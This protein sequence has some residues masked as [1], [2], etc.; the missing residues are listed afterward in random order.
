[1]YTYYTLN[2]ADKTDEA[3]EILRLNTVLYPEDI[4][5]WYVLAEAEEN[6][7]NL[8]DAMECYNRLLS[9]EPDIPDVRRSYNSL[10]LLDT[11]IDRGINDVAKVFEYLKK[12]HPDEINEGTLNNLGYRL[13]RNKKIQDAIKIFELNVDLH[14]DYANGYDSLAEAYMNAGENELAIKNY[15][16]SLELE[17]GNNNAKE[18]LKKLRKQK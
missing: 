2:P 5:A 3:L 11:F 10:L 9:I 7:G 15:R 4:R 1:M 14:P 6:K 8:K 18:M 16:K 12:N 13:L 17:P